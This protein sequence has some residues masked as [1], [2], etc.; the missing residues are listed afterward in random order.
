[1]S[2]CATRSGMN[3]LTDQTEGSGS[4]IGSMDSARGAILEIEGRRTKDAMGE[5]KEL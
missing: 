2:G 4:S 5:R 3:F 1:V